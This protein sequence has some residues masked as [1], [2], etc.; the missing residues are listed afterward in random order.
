MNDR[1]SDWR[2]RWACDR[3]YATGRAV[4]WATALVAAGTPPALVLEA[5]AAAAEAVRGGVDAAAAES[6]RALA[7]QDPTG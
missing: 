1:D 5:L 2:A 6:L 7:A 3:A 4:D